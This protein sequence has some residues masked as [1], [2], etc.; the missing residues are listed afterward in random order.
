MRVSLVK[1]AGAGSTG[2]AT[3]ALALLAWLLAYADRLVA[4]GES[5]IDF[6]QA[7]TMILGS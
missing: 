3:T 5:I 1:G 2:A 7:I 6:V 4:I